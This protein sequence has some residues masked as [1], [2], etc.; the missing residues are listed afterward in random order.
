MVSKRDI[1]PYDY[2]I[3]KDSLSQDKYHEGTDPEFFYDEK[4]VCYVYEDDDGP[5]MYVKGS[6]VLRL[7]IQFVLNSDFRRNAAGLQKLSE[8]VEFA[9][10]AGFKQLIFTSNSPLLRKYCCKHFG[11]AESKDELIREL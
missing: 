10:T 5:I 8:I 7:D 4:A 9:K 3:L 1:E 11:F 6:K 2:P